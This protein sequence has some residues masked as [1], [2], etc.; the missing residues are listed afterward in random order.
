MAYGNRILEKL[1]ALQEESLRNVAQQRL[2]QGAFF[3]KNAKNPEDFREAGEI[4][5]RGV[6]EDPTILEGQYGLAVS[7]EGMGNVA[8]AKRRFRNVGRLAGDDKNELAIGA[9]LKLARLEEETGNLPSAI[10]ATR[11]ALQRDIKNGNLRLDLARV[12]ALSGFEEESEKIL[13]ELIDEDVQYLLKLKLDPAFSHDLLLGVYT[14]LWENGGQ[15]KRGIKVTVFLLR[16][17]ASLGEKERAF[18]VFK[19]L[20]KGGPRL[21]LAN[22]LLDSFTAPDAAT[23]AADYIKEIIVG[24]EDPYSAEDWYAL[25]F[26]AFKLLKLKQANSKICLT[27][28]TIVSCFRRALIHDMYLRSGD[29]NAVSHAFEQLDKENTPALV[30]LICSVE[31]SLK[32]FLTQ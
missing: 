13:L 7:A 28:E 9:W 12:L 17:F 31:P 19:H 6:D 26:L 30:E 21:V 18:A 10:E 32:P 29:R 1:L 8:E 5:Q 23:V 4:F 20:M 3:L 24:E 2:R 11:Q 16:E 15:T 22:R 25:T 27:P 14:N